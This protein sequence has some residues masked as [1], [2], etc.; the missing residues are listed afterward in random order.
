MT[1]LSPDDIAK[2]I[3]HLPSLPIVVLDVLKSFEQPEASVGELADKVARDQAL[4]AK[5][6]R[7]ANSSFYGLSRKVTTIQ[8]AIT[9]L[10]FD[11]VRALIAA[12]AV[13][14]VFSSG[15]Q[16]GFDFKAFWRHAIGTGLWAKMLARQLKLNQDYAFVCGLLH[17]IG[18]LVLVTRFPEQ[19]AA[20]MRYRTQKDCYV[21]EAERAVLEMD[22]AAVGRALADYW[23]FP[24]IMQKAI[25]DH[26]EPQ[27]EDLR[28][29]PAVVHIA[30]AT[31]HA[32]DMAQDD[33]DLV[34]VVSEDAW[35]SLGLEACEFRGMCRDAEAEFEEA[36]QILVV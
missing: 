23:K 27:G 3:R 20:A 26:H 13:T 14:D 2:G 7:I 16:G 19:Y 35:K 32:L 1:R 34:P 33:D 36:C 11:S 9:I 12:A 8:Q 28:D 22:H 10:G 25:A 17:D 29:V 15:R 24:V 30:E 4:A 21:I 31:V 18:R 6:L 5:T